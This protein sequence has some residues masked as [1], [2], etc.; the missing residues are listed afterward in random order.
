MGF[1]YKEIH[2]ISVPGVSSNLSRWGDNIG[3]Y[4]FYIKAYT[5]QI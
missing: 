1:E 5:L 4:L 3:S 2:E